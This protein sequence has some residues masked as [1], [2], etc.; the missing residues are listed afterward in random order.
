MTTDNITIDAVLDRDLLGLL[1]KLDLID[2]INDSK[3]TCSRCDKIIT[4][5]NIGAVGID[6]G[7]ARI[8]CDD[9]VCIG[10]EDQV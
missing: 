8:Y 10:T 6:E 3:A 5:E 7:I 1:K 2:R 4:L 9:F